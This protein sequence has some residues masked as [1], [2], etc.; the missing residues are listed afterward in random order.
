MS[1]IHYALVKN[2]IVQ[3][4]TDQDSSKVGDLPTH[5]GGV[6]IVSPAWV[7]T[8]DAYDGNV[9]TRPEPS[10]PPA[11]PCEWLIDVGPFF[12]RFGAAKM[13]VL[14]STHPIA[15]AVVLDAQVRKW[16]DLEREDVAEGIDALIT[17]PIAGV[18]EAL[19]TSILT[20]PVEAE[21]NRA[22][23]KVYFQ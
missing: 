2:G 11:D 3:T 1:T 4:A 18:D 23:R 14:T 15:K 8:G 13:A 7:G 21:E 17:I 16:I 12:D 22:L 19:K 9:F 6:W 10:G 20:T 5:L